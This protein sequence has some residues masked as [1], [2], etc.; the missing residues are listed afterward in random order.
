MKKLLLIAAILSLQS[1]VA[2]TQDA[3]IFF[4]DKENVQVSIDNPITILTQEAIDRKALHNVPIDARDVPVT[5]AYITQVKA[6]NGITWLAKSK[7]MN[8]VYVQGTQANIEALLDLSF[9]T[10][11]E[12]MDKDMNTFPVPDRYGVDDKF[13]IEKINNRIVYNYGA[14]A[15]QIEMINGDYLHEEDFTGEGMIIA[16]LDSGFPDGQVMMHS[17]T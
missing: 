16:I 9:V 12:W 2:Q 14:A 13:A 7:W 11:V 17:R 8:C 6:A 10:G 3:L 4:A 1:G 15:N 5:E